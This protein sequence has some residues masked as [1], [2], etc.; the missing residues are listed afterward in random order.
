MTSSHLLV[1]PS[2][3]A[4]F[5]LVYIALTYPCTIGAYAPRLC[6]TNHGGLVSKARCKPF[7]L[8]LPA[9]GSVV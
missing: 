6:W 2:I 4:S 5:N 9:D 8:V 7:I 3:T 1:H